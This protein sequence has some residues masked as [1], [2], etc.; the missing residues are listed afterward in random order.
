MPTFFSYVS[1]HDKCCILPIGCNSFYLTVYSE[2]GVDVFD[3]NAMEWVQ[4]IGLRKVSP[5]PVTAKHKGFLSF[6]KPSLLVC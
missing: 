4:T 3:V 6:L 5:S 1:K 2:Y